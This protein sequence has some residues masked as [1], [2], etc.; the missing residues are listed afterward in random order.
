MAYELPPLPYDYN[1]LEPYIDEQTMR[2][3]HDKHHQAY[4]D[5]ANQALEKLAQARATG[6]F[7]AVNLYTNNLCFNLSGHVLHSI[8]WPNMSPR[9]GGDPSGELAKQIETDFSSVDAFRKHFTAAAL[10]VQ[11][12]GWAIAAWDPVGKQ[13][14][15]VQAEKHQDV[16]AQGLSPILVLDVWEHA[17]YLKYQ[18]QRAK[19]V[20]AWWNV[21]NWED[22][23]ERLA[24]AKSAK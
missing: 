5:G 2:L 12:S 3:H 11:G 19:Y 7:S 8:F 14:V 20:E 1:A 16:T 10:G 21:V 6:D 4:V 22:V 9:G 15:I 13:I 23:A 18:N 24:N 17:Y